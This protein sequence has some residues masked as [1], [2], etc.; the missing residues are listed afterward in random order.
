MFTAGE[1]H[2]QSASIE[3][4]GSPAATPRPC[5]HSQP[6]RKGEVPPKTG[7][8]AVG[9]PAFPP[10]SSTASL[11]SPSPFN[12][13]SQIQNPQSEAPGSPPR[14]AVPLTFNPIINDEANILAAIARGDRTLPDLAEEHGT[15][16]TALC[17]WLQREDIQ[18][19]LADLTTAGATLTRIAAVNNLP[20]AVSALS[21]QIDGYIFDRTHNLIK[22]GLDA[23]RVA[24]TRDAN[25]RKAAH[26]LLRLAKFD[27]NQ[28]IYRRRDRADR[29]IPST[30]APHIADRT[31]LGE[32]RS[33]AGGADGGAVERS[34][35][36]GALLLISTFRKGVGGE[37]ASAQHEQVRGAFSKLTHAQVVTP[38]FAGETERA[39]L[40]PSTSPE[41]EV[42]AKVGGPGVGAPAFPTSSSFCLSHIPL[43]TSD[44]EPDYDDDPES[45]PAPEPSLANSS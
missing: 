6:P 25:V 23:D 30:L 24:A 42:P 44:F 36:E 22:P 12:P 9:A 17:L 35:T 39:R 32:A 19:K 26:L 45:E 15:T 31:D 43:P 33:P 40:L 29:T 8:A 20:K 27:P 41:G 13:Q 38:D 21:F 37:E 2:I 18:R 16:V 4:E 10:V 5:L 28:P 7:G 11:P 14:R 34:E 1:L 3:P